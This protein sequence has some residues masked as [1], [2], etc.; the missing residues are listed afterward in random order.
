MPA[1]IKTPGD[2]KRWAKAKEAANKT[3]SE[4]EGDS[5]WAIV[6]SI[7]QKMTK[8]IDLALEL[9]DEEALSKVITMLEKADDE[10][11]DV[12][13]ELGEGFHEID[14][15]A[16]ESE[17]EDWLKE[18]DP[19]QGGEYEEYGDDEDEEAHRQN[20]E[21]DESAEEVPG[22]EDEAGE[23]NASGVPQISEKQL[24]SMPKAVRDIYARAQ[25]SKGSQPQKVEEAAPQEVK[26]TSRFRQPSPEEIQEMRGYTRPWE[27]RARETAKLNADPSKNPV[28]HHQGQIIEA[29]EKAHGGRKA[30]Y[31]QLIN[32]DDYKNADPMQQMEMDDNF[33]RD[34]KQK[35][36]EHLKNAITEHHAANKKGEGAKA[37]HAAAKDAEIRNII[38]GGSNPEESMST[39]A[40][41]Q[42][43]GGV[44]GEEGT[45]GRIM[46]DPSA[47]FAHSN[48][49]FI[50]QYAQDYNKK[51][52][53]PESAE[54]MGQYDE[55]SKKDVARI[56]GPGPSKNP[57]VE[58]FFAHYH[59]LIGMSA[60]KVMKKLG[61][62]PKSPEMDM[63]ML[64]EAGMHGLMQA[65][66][67]YN[68][69]HP[70]KASFSTHAGNKIRGLMQ[71]ALRDQDKIPAEMRRAQKQYSKTKAPPVKTISSK[72]LI[73][74]HP[75]GPEIGERLGRIQAQKALM[76]KKPGGQG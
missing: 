55:A 31:Q 26:R 7:Y 70:S 68:H 46:Q 36:P 64:H 63:S 20:I 75:K 15:D 71:T 22:A 74:S 43:V 12:D 57:K 38:Q 65:I 6:N 66:N 24:A 30:A 18:N 8:A 23:E 25:Q 51:A 69:Q 5:Y 4:S 19:E 58:Q 61:L 27:Q 52:K 32:S 21:D 37:Q 34:W 28:L 59:P 53:K 40:A 60:S 39:E 48:P 72:D 17:G 42:N 16:E 10:F 73:G 2:E 56:L 14:P 29:R 54:D 50:K 11:D 33:E 76:P 62:D 44:K 41:L 1:F 45:T 3:H 49:D 47:S 35:N 9:G 13:D 67:D